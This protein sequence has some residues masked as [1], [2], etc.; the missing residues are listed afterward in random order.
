M[1][2]ETTIYFLSTKQQVVDS[3]RQLYERQGYSF[4]AL[5]VN[6]ELPDDLS[7]LL[8]IEPLNLSR[9]Y[10]S[11]NQLW[12]NYLYKHRP[13]CRLIVATYA[14]NRHANV[15]SLLSLPPNLETFLNNVKPVSDYPFVHIGT[16]EKGGEKQDKYMDSWSIL[17]PHSGR[18]ALTDMQRFLDGHDRSKS[19]SAQLY[20][21]RK[22]LR[23]WFNDTTEERCHRLD[24]IDEEFVYL[25]QRWYF[26]DKIFDY[27]PFADTM[28]RISEHLTACKQKID[29][30][31]APDEA[32]LDWMADIYD[33]TQDAINP[34]VFPLDYW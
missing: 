34:I 30:N 28:R 23:E 32:V 22:L 17:L 21:M 9:E 2:N 6:K 33:L 7:Y 4:A 27:L 29:E 16:E 18:P 19:F 24:E 5:D 20:R 10:Y 14:D 31:K 1:N 15:L 12:K 25:L 11:V 8:L 13:E 26:Y 3:L